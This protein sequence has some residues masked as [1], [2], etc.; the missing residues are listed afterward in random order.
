MK[1]VLNRKKR[2]RLFVSGTTLLT[3]SLFLLIAPGCQEEQ[4]EMGHEE[5]PQVT[6]YFDFS[7]VKDYDIEINL[8]LTPDQEVGSAVYYIYTEDPF[9]YRNGI[10]TEMLKD[11]IS[12]AYKGTT[13]AYGTDEIKLNIPLANNEIYI[14]TSGIG[15]PHTLTVPV[16][17]NPLRVNA[18]E[19][20][21]HKTKQTTRATNAL[22][23]R[24]TAPGTFSWFSWNEN[25]V[26]NVLLTPEVFPA[27]TLTNIRYS[28]PEGLNIAN[29]PVAKDWVNPTAVTTIDVID[30]AAIDVAFIH[31]GAGYTNVFGY[32]YYP[33]GQPPTDIV[34]HPKYIIFPN[35]SL[36]GSGGNLASG[37]RIQ[38]KY[39]NKD[40]YTDTFPP[41][42]TIGWLLF[43]N[44]FKASP[45]YTVSS[46]NWLLTSDPALNPSKLQQVIQLVDPA[47]ND[48]LVSF[49]DWRRDQGGDKDF[50]DVIFHAS[51]NPYTAVSVTGVP[52]LPMFKDPDGDG[53]PN[54]YDEFP[55]DPILAYT[56]HYPGNKTVDPSKWGTLCYEDHWPCNGDYDMN[57][58]VI[59]YNMVHYINAQK[60]VVYTTGSLRVVAVGAAMQSGFVL[61]LGIRPELVKKVTVNGGSLKNGLFNINANGC[62]AYQTTAHVPLWDDAFLIFGH[63]VGEDIN[64][65]MSKDK[66]ASREVTF[67]IDYTSPV[68]QTSF[69][70]LPFDPYVTIESGRRER[71]RECHVSGFAPSVLAD[72]NMFSTCNDLTDIA[73]KQYYVGQNN[74]PFALHFPTIVQYPVERVNITEAYLHFFDWASSMGVNYKDW[75]Y[76][77]ASGYKNPANIYS[78]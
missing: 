56:N 8:N 30:K 20:A 26:P 73:K 67:R 37:S 35:T 3:T 78:K 75:Y 51:A 11:N 43:A 72:K 69:I 66:I 32:Y 62:E 42:I 23:N 5:A 38:L 44:G 10:N 24:I 57:D 2:N 61:N 19:I 1:S 6:T 16:T 48:I 36:P 14:V 52:T 54:Q 77:T 29:N 60:N 76:N 47:T 4:L 7:M 39:F 64:T 33:T 63:A 21:T 50:N 31:E 34:N 70:T 18:L 22:Y 49:E 74:M 27:Q 13:S 40:H 25:G 15:M 12:P 68:A 59:H 9:I 53:V 17:G 55:N 41:G 58:Q 46:G 65:S 45:N 28:L 71:G